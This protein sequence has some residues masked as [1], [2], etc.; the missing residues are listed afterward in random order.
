MKQE[1]VDSLALIGSESVT[2]PHAEAVAR[3]RQLAR[4]IDGRAVVSEA[5]GAGAAPRI[6]QSFTVYLEAVTTE[7][8]V[9]TVKSY[10]SRDPWTWLLDQLEQNRLET[11]EADLIRGLR[12]LAEER[13]ER[14]TILNRIDAL[15]ARSEPIEKETDP[16]PVEEVSEEPVRE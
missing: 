13:S 4:E 16:A 2:G 12:V 14:E 8:G 1:L 3:L 7:T 6:I 15:E 5:L 11:A 10:F 9:P